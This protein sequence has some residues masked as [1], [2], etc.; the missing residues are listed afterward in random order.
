MGGFLGEVSASLTLMSG[1]E[2]KTCACC[3]NQV[4]AAQSYN[5]ASADG[6]FARV[7]EMWSS[8]LS[9]YARGE[10]DYTCTNHVMCEECAIEYTRV[11]TESLKPQKKALGK[12]WFQCPLCSGGMPL[13]P[14]VR[15]EERCVLDC[16]KGWRRSTCYGEENMYRAVIDC[17]LKNLVKVKAI[18]RPAGPFCIDD[19]SWLSQLATWRWHFDD[20][21]D[22]DYSNIVAKLTVE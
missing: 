1:G 21:L 2:T 9:K 8:S 10:H 4:T 12:T 6:T 16:Q 18:K 13:C 20:I 3:S 7:N 11:F 19:M 17:N 14:P 15:A 5:C 22:D